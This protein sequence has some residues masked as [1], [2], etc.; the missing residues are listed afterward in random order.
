MDSKELL[1]VIV[2]ALTS[3]PN[4]HYYEG[5][6]GFQGEFYAQL[7]LRL[8]DMALPEGALLREEYQKIGGA[9]SADPPGHYSSRAVRS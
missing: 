5:E 3:V 4:P 1:N 7:R 9:W 8:R 6:R 2:A